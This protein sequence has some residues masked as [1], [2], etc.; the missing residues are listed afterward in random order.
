ME[1]HPLPFYVSG[2]GPGQRHHLSIEGVYAFSPAA[3]VGAG[4][5]IDFGPDEGRGGAEGLG[6]GVDLGPCL[7]AAIG[8]GKEADELLEE[9]EVIGIRSLRGL[10]GNQS[11]LAVTPRR[12]HFD[13]DLGGN[14]GGEP[15][16]TG[17]L[18]HQRVDGGP[19]LLA[20]RTAQLRR[21]PH[22]QQ[23]SPELR[24]GDELLRRQTRGQL[25]DDRDRLVGAT[26]LL[27]IRRFEELRQ[28][29]IGRPGG[30]TTTGLRGSQGVAEGI[31]AIGPGDIDPASERRIGRDH[32]SQPLPDRQ[33]LRP[34][35]LGHRHGCFT[36]EDG[37]GIRG[38]RFAPLDERTA[39]LLDPA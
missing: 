2:P 11:R 8:R 7:V 35:P 33:R 29:R 21:Q 5:D 32:R 16:V 22:S 30:D 25:L 39:N 4:E 20:R 38:K 10:R 1:R 36:V 3:A 24:L 34:P 15:P 14:V 13:A 9:L 17:E 28:V 12:E 31:V 6:G 26:R 18:V 37:R 27:Q 19:V 23:G